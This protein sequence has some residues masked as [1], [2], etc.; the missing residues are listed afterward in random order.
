MDSPATG[1]F[2][3]M[4]CAYVSGIYIS[5]GLKVFEL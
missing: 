4:L 2:P 5:C 1:M 3:I